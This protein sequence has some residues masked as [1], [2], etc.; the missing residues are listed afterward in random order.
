MGDSK[1]TTFGKLRHCPLCGQNFLT[2][3]IT[4]FGE[5]RHVPSAHCRSIP[6]LSIPG[7]ELRTN[8]GH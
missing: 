3:Q 7:K 4:D 2:H 8:L 6:L 5:R 1:Y